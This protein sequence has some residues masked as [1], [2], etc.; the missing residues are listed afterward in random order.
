MLI[1]NRKEKE[2]AE[3]A[4][5]ALEQA[6]KATSVDAFFTREKANEG[7]RLNLSTPEGAPTEHWIQVRGIDS[8]EYRR[9]QTALSRRAVEVAMIQDEKEYADALE[10]ME[11]EARAA[12]VIDW[13]L[14]IEC[15][16]SEV[17]KFFRKAPQISDEVFRQAK[18]RALFFAKKRASS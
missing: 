12:L 6:P 11:Q 15:S 10:R 2:P 16:R 7:I 3:K 13:S 4:G 5:D 17:V 18:S 1:R 8:D 14:P 9:A